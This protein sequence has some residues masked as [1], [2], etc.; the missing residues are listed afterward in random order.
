MPT[1]E[2]EREPTIVMVDAPQRPVS[3]TG[4]D[5]VAMVV[6]TPSSTSMTAHLRADEIAAMRAASMP[7]PDKAPAVLARA[8]MQVAAAAPAQ[9]GLLEGVL[10]AVLGFLFG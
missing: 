7:A 1:S 3:T 8:N 2:P 4:I 5:G 10:G 9:S 6:S